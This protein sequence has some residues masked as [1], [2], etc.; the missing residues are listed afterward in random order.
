MTIKIG[1]H[2]ANGKMGQVITQ[3]ARDD[4]DI[5]IA[6]LYARNSEFND[7][8]KLFESSDII[9]DF[10][11]HQVID[12]LLRK[13]V[14]FK[15]KLLIGTTGINNEHLAAMH[16]AA[17]HVAVF[18]SPNTSVGVYVMT[19]AAT[20]AANLL[21]NS[22]DATIIDVHHKHKKDAPSGTSL[23][24]GEKITNARNFANKDSSANSIDFCSIRAGNQPAKVE[25][26][27]SGAH[28]SLSI[29]HNAYSRDTFASGALNI[30]KWLKNAPARMYSMDD[31][32]AANM[33]N[34]DD[35]NLN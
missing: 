13:A 1:L 27:F 26:M 8:D 11:N 20:L 12:L 29:I 18:Y 25:V 19:K 22:Y 4:K 24:L 17:M 15:K 3:L 16:V 5:K 35:R 2:G 9:I 34:K 33:L 6:Y 28:E 30:V 31:Y 10:S 23:L 32:I 21:G 7:L 14:E